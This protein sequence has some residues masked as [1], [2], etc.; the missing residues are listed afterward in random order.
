MAK[1]RYPY[2]MDFFDAEFFLD[3]DSPREVGEA[4]I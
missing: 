3:T 4:A 2:G 1:M